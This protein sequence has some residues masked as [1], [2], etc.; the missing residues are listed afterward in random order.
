MIHT[1]THAYPDVP[2]GY[3]GHEIGLQTTVAAVALGA[4][5]VERHITLDRAN[6]GSD[7]AAS[8]EPGGLQRLVRDIRI[9]RG[10]ARRRRQA[11]LRQ[12]AAGAAQAA[13]ASARARRR[14][15]SSRANA[16]GRA[17]RERHPAAQRRRVG[18]RA[19][20][21]IDDL[22]VVVLAPRDRQPRA[23]ARPGRARWRAALGI[24]VRHRSVLRRATPPRSPVRRAASRDPCARAD[25][26][27]IGDPFSALRADA[28]AAR[29]APARSWSSTTAPRRGSS[30]AASTRARRWCAGTS[31][32]RAPS[33]ARGP[34]DPAAVTPSRAA[35][36]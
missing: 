35:R 36:G 24:E 27:V 11:G 16:H 26:L 12:R 17:G 7:Q 25:R 15:M 34:R 3:S 10:R 8:V 20:G 14:G 13:R 22:R 5:F 31:R 4:C 1:L 18:A 32:R 23:P 21:S 19:T 33:G 6:W 28:A 30:C 2:I 29:R 9:G